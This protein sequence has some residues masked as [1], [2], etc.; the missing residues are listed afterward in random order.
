V[1]AHVKSVQDTMFKVATRSVEFALER[2]IGRLESRMTEKVEKIL[3]QINHDY[4][5][6]LVNQNIFRALSSS[7]DD[8]R[9]LLS[10]VDQRF[11]Q[12]LRP[13]KHEHAAAMSAF[14]KASGIVPKAGTPLKVSGSGRGTPVGASVPR[15]PRRTADGKVRIKKEPSEDVRMR[16]A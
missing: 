14:Y 1:I 12:V 3:G 2:T 7:R 15:P 10:G 13:I 16:D 4:S 6:L 5:S 8:V 9:N 11:E